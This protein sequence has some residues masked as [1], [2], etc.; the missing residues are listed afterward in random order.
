[1]LTCD[2]AE[3]TSGQY[4][5]GTGCPGSLDVDECKRSLEEQLQLCFGEVDVSIDLRHGCVW[6]ILDWWYDA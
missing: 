3:A 4:L 5:A 2:G 1:M 6:G